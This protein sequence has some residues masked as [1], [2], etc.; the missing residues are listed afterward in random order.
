[1]HNWQD[2]RICTKV[3]LLSSVHSNY[4][5]SKTMVQRKAFNLSGLQM[6]SQLLGGGNYKPEG[7]GLG[8]AMPVLAKVSPAANNFLY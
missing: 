7:S 1:M 5:Y 6:I 3:I 2:C 8:P 4:G